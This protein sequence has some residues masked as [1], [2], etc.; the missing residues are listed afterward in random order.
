MKHS[1][2]RM[3]TFVSLR[4]EVIN[5]QEEGARAPPRRSSGFTFP[6]RDAPSPS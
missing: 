2:T 4:P 6:N 5:H 3:C 1:K